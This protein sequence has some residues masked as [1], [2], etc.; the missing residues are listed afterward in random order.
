MPINFNLAYS[1]TLVGTW[2]EGE[3]KRSAAR[4]CMD[5]LDTPKPY[6]FTFVG[7]LHQLSL[8]LKTKS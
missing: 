5:S 6:Y 7:V 1:A 2:R 8:A 4:T 3:E